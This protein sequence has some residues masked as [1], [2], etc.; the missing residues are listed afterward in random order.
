MEQLNKL[1]EQV[2]SLKDIANNLNEILCTIGTLPTLDFNDNN[3]FPEKLHVMEVI[4][5]ASWKMKEIA[6]LVE[7][8]SKNSV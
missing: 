1:K 7:A 8:S 6:E 3:T 4:S 2:S 5:E